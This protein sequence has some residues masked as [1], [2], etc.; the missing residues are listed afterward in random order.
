M[1]MNDEPEPG[2]PEPQ[3]GDTEPSDLG[4]GESEADPGEPEADAASSEPMAAAEAAPQAFR[5][6]VGDRYLGGVASGAGRALGIDATIVRVGL[7]VV[8]VFWAIVPLV[9]AALWLTIR[10][11]GADRS[12]L[13]SVQKPGGLRRIVSV[14]VLG[15]GATALASDLRGSGAGSARFGLLLVAGGLVLILG[16]PNARGWR[17]GPDFV[18]PAGP[19]ATHQA[20]G[21]AA[22]SARQSEGRRQG[23]WSTRS[24]RAP[25]PPEPGPS[26]PVLRWLARGWLGWLGLS[27]V[28]LVA[29]A[30]LLLD[31]ARGTVRPG[32]AVVVGLLIVAVGLLVGARRGRAHILI[33]AGLLLTPLWLGFSLSDVPRYEGE[34][35]DVYRP[36]NLADLQE[37]YSNGYGTLVVDLTELALPDGE[38]QQIDLGLTAGEIEVIVPSDVS[39]DVSGDVGLGGGRLERRW[40]GRDDYRTMLADS[41]EGL[42]AGKDLSIDSPARPPSC[43]DH[44]LDLRDTWPR[45]DV[46]GPWPEDFSP[47]DLDYER[48]RREDAAKLE[49]GSDRDEDGGTTSTLLES[50]QDTDPD[51][52]PCTPQPPPTNPPLVEIDVRLGMG[53]MEVHH[54]ETPA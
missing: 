27:L 46:D 22:G 25:L 50:R 23:A 35:R 31:W 26:V 53:V 10:E 2:D 11:D 20:H 5:R 44:Y 1:G 24:D 39:V 37:D 52:V 15:I 13:R 34:G 45:D 6:S 54:V 51:G 14:V 21:S 40:E 8:T 19:I 47:Q 7:A 42:V 38:T 12:L 16:G 49:P 9:Y 48:Q 3:G 18:E 28:G 17:S 41:D 29:G 36:T 32:W 4:L 30:A 33:P 43:S